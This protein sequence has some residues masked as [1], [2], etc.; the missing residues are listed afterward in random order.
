MLAPDW[1]LMPLVILAGLASL[2][3][4]VH[5]VGV[6]TRHE[7]VREAQGLALTV[8]NQAITDSK[9]DPAKALRNLLAVL[10]S[11][12]RLEGSTVVAVTPSTIPWM[13]TGW[14]TEV[15]APAVATKR[16]CHCSGS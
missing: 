2:A 5:N 7:L 8:Q 15:E 4:E 3:L 11:P 9:T 1:A 13:T 10:K 6:Q 12:L 14:S 16:S